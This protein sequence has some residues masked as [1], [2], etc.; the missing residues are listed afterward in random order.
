LRAAIGHQSRSQ[1]LR[2]GRTQPPVYAKGKIQRLSASGQKA[3][4]SERVI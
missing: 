1:H 4:G 2:P 3:T